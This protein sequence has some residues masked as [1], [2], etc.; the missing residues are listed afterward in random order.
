MHKSNIKPKLFFNREGAKWYSLLKHTIFFVFILL[1][2]TH[3]TSIFS[4]ELKLNSISTRPD[5]APQ[6]SSVWV[7]SF[8]IEAIDKKMTITEIDVLNNGNDNP[9]AKGFGNGITSVALYKDDGNGAFTDD[10]DLAGKISGDNLAG[11]RT[12]FDTNDFSI[13]MGISTGNEET[14][15]I[16][17]TVDEDTQAGTTTDVQLEKIVY[18]D[19][20]GT[21]GLEVTLND[22]NIVNDIYISGFDLYSAYDI[23]PEAAIPGS[24]E[25]PILR[26]KARAA[27]NE[28]GE[29]E[30]FF[31]DA[32]QDKPIKIRIYNAE[33]NFV[34]SKDSTN[35]IIKAR[36]YIP[37]NFGIETYD[38]DNPEQYTL[39]KTISSSSEEFTDSYYCTFEIDSTTKFFARGT[40]TNLFVTYEL[41]EDFQVETDSKIK[42]RLVSITAVGEDSDIEIIKE[43][44]VPETDAEA[45]VAGLVYDE[46]SAINVR[47]S[48]FGSGNEAPI[49]RYK[50]KA[51][52]TAIRLRSLVI[53]NK[54]ESYN[55]DIIPFVLDENNENGITKISVYEDTKNNG[56]LDNTDTLIG[57]INLG[58]SDSGLPGKYNDRYLPISG[59][60]YS[61]AV[62][63]FSVTSGD[64]LT[65]NYTIS[66]D[67]EKQLLVIYHLGKEVEDGASGTT[68]SSNVESYT[69]IA[70]LGDALGYTTLDEE[71]VITVNLSGTLPVAASPEAEINISN[72]QV[73]IRNVV[74]ISPTTVIRGQ[75][76]VPMLALELDA[77]DEVASLSIYVKNS[78]ET[79]TAD[80]KGVDK[81]LVYQ[82]NA[83]GETY[84]TFGAEDELL[85][86][87][88]QLSDRSEGVVNNVPFNQQT[89]RF[90]ICYN[91][92]QVAT[93][94]DQE[95]IACQLE[96]IKGTLDNGNELYFGGYLPTPQ[97][98][99]IC[100]IKDKR[101]SITSIT[102][103]DIDSSS[104][105]T[106][107]G[108]IH[109]NV[110]N[111]SD[112]LTI[113]IKDIIPRFY[114]SE[115]S[116][117]D[118]SSEF[119][120]IYADDYA[121]DKPPNLDLT[122]GETAEV[123]YNIK[124]TSRD[125]DGTVYVDAY[126]EYEITST[127]SAIVTRYEEDSSWNTGALESITIKV[128]ADDEDY[129][130]EL[131][132]Y[133]EKMEINYESAAN[134]TFVNYD[135]LN[136]GDTIWI[137]LSNNGNNILESSLL[138]GIY[139]DG[140]Q[141]S[142]TTGT[143]DS[144]TYSYDNTEGILKLKAGS[145]DG[146]F[147]I[148]PK[149][150]NNKDLDSSNIYYYIEN[151]V[152]IKT[153]LFYPNP[154]QIGSQDLIL[155][156]GLTQPATVKVYM[157]NH[158]GALVWTH[159]ET[160]STI[161]Y[162]EITIN[163]LDS[164]LRSGMYICKLIAEDDNGNKDI[165]TTKLVIY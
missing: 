97:D 123:F 36:L 117:A 23:A 98:P 62:I 115:I 47:D 149:D 79:F 152:K 147:T 40:T 5:F 73:N 156:F 164:F 13:S 110:K 6:G 161:D 144:S 76:S 38:Q 103:P 74:D 101:V 70:R 124:H 66:E 83:D 30:G 7:Y 122:P 55:G 159:E 78:K 130:F 20:D 21:T 129:S 9:S 125:S 27:G 72:T 26:I 94:I 68:I 46:V 8:S 100:S 142:K 51:H 24:G 146:Y 137:Y 109:V 64:T 120:V 95:I 88:D 43:E 141:I 131:P 58:L 3:N 69:A 99:A 89:N 59:N 151:K 162:Q 111:T 135:V 134:D 42:S 63:T 44:S 56:N 143:L 81:I 153:P 104:I 71:S 165:A 90:I 86:A 136:S 108:D 106:A 52:N 160:F 33:G 127:Q 116:G 45:D 82:D 138:N 128:Q 84:G 65:N 163:S 12:V 15:F 25:V 28:D 126:V 145:S 11:V 139:R 18:K 29:G 35:G 77:E 80:G 67:G 158:I 121:G 119:T 154:F 157:F 57:E 150:L 140:V 1:F 87:S 107:S 105:L 113:T 114:L 37:F 61:E 102:S 49:L 32:D 39:V 112:T 17:Y 75:Q 96:N 60:D 2:I 4:A 14:F 148:S 48:I 85:A 133:I 118:I 22:L 16:V 93:P 10:D 34:T 54:Y 92:G 19:S 132:N 91:I 155:G 50:L 53:E 31:P 41:G